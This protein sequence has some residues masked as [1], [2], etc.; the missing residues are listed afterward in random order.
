M[1]S[2]GPEDASADSERYMLCFCVVNHN[3]IR[4]TSFLSLGIQR[5]MCVDGFLAAVLAKY[6]GILNRATAEIYHVP[7]GFLPTSSKKV[8]SDGWVE[9]FF[10]QT[11]TRDEE[12]LHADP[13]RWTK[14]P[15]DISKIY[16][17][18]KI[19][20]PAS[21]KV[22]DGDGASRMLRSIPASIETFSSKTV[23]E[24]LPL[25]CERGTPALAPSAL[26][27]M[28]PAE[29]YKSKLHR[30]INYNCPRETESISLTLL[31]KVFGQF[32]DDC[33]REPDFE[34]SQVMN[35]YAKAALAMV[36]DLSEPVDGKLLM[37]MFNSRFENLYD[38]TLTRTMHSFETDGHLVRNG[39]LALLRELKSRNPS[40]DALVQGANHYRYFYVNRRKELDHLPEGDVL[41]AFLITYQGPLINVYGIACVEKGQVQCEYLTSVNAGCH[42]TNK[43]EL[44]KLTRILYALRKAFDRLDELPEL[45]EA[46]TSPPRKRQKITR[47]AQTVWPYTRSF[48]RLGSNTVVEF[49]YLKRLDGERYLFEVQPVDEPS[50]KK[51]LVKFTQSYGRA[52]HEELAGSNY[53]PELLGFSNLSGGWKMVVM[54]YLESR[55]WKDGSSCKLPEEDEVVRREIRTVRNKIL[56]LLQEKGYVHGDIRLDNLMFRMDRAGDDSDPA[57]KLVDFDFAGEAGK[58]A[59][60]WN[61]NT[62]CRPQGQMPCAPLE[63]SHDD[64]SLKMT[65]RTI[66]SLGNG[67]GL[68][69]Y[70]YS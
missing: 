45:S 57:V 20:P 17:V 38:F 70:H 27:K 12:A 48:I 63:F 5:G 10:M 39:R 67:A 37:S 29:L 28:S 21:V 30:L 47:P 69:H 4:I 52:V 1:S 9:V 41:P 65:E 49:L 22:I 59:Y 25:L 14:I 58:T 11:F 19:P 60:P 36:E 51:L 31:S 2:N 61:L 35:T 42:W 18:I 56:P 34:V 66:R 54:E 6:P 13:A 68:R 24:R 43:E 32:K 50:S 62:A 44:Y 55:V 46:P 40:G 15:D 8:E 53:A 23:E 16:Y 64:A 3:F 7:G 33:N 26:A